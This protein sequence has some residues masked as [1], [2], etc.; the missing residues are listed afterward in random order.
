MPNT[1]D[2]T[3]AAFKEVVPKQIRARITQDLV[4]QTNAIISDPEVREMYRDN[5]LTYTSVL[6]EGKF[7]LI[8]YLDAV[9]YVGFKLMGD[10][11][12]KA[13]IKTFPDKYSGWKLLGMPEKEIH[14][15]VSAFN[16]KK[17]V[18]LIWGK[19]MIPSHV[20]NQDYYQK[21][22]NTQVDLMLHANSEKVRSDAA[23]S[24]LTHLKPPETAKLEIEIG[25]KDT[26]AIS[27]LRAA[28]LALVNSQTDMMKSGMLN[29]QTVAHSK[30]TIDN[31]SGSVVE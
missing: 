18:N 8:Q 13:Y 26:G 30:L 27:D 9:R 16:K 24:V 17:L 29:P 10:T 22:L 1:G 5:I 31:D 3:L 12:I 15:Y 2:L 20:L 7:T 21:A 28:T 4:D 23:N 14:T 11:N 25:Q 19:S 6:Q